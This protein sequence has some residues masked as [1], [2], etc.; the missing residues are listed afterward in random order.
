MPAGFIGNS[1][2]NRRHGARVECQLVDGATR[3]R[4]TVSAIES[5][6]PERTAP[7]A[8]SGRPALAPVERRPQTPRDDLDMERALG[9][10]FGTVQVR[11]TALALALAALGAA[12]A[13]SAQAQRGA[14]AAADDALRHGRY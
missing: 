5:R 3:A 12:F 14:L 10:G 6:G 7:S 2:A 8:R 4:V 1:G 13:P 11:R 9:G